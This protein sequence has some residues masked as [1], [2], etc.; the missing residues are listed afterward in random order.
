LI[1]NL[2]NSDFLPWIGRQNKTLRPDIPYPAKSENELLHVLHK[3]PNNDFRLLL[4]VSHTP[5]NVTSSTMEI[6]DNNVEAGGGSGKVQYFTPHQKNDVQ[7]FFKFY[8]AVT[9]NIEYAGRTTVKDTTVIRDLI[10]FLNSLKG[11]PVDTPL[12]IYEEI[13]P[14]MIEEVKV[15]NTL[16]E[17]E[18]TNG[19]ILCFQKKIN[20]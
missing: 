15:N 12:T 7:L 13:K 11:F 2:K 6:D 16:Q 17:S 9:Q 8:D 14:Q 4:E 3:N 1:L 18:L 10:P 5:V 19:D 20:S